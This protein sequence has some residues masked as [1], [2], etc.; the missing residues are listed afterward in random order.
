MRIKCAAIRNKHGIIYEG[1]DHSEAYKNSYP[2]AFRGE[3]GFVTDTGKF[4]D[5]MKAADI[6]FS[7]GQISRPKGCLFSEDLK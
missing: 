2:N 7:A 6:A 5:R 4:V 1:K 3:Q